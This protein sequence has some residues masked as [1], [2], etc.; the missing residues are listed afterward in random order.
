MGKIRIKL[1]WIYLIP[2]I[3]FIWSILS[4]FNIASFIPKAEYHFQEPYIIEIEK[5]IDYIITMNFV[6]DGAFVAGKK[7][8]V[9]VE[10]S[11][12]IGKK[13]VD[14][15]NIIFIEGSS[16]YPKKERAYGTYEGGMMYLMVIDG[17]E[18]LVGSEL[19]YFSSPGEYNIYSGL[20]FSNEDGQLGGKSENKIHIS[21]PE[22]WLNV[23]Q[24]NRILAL[25]LII[26]A[27][28]LFSIFHQGKKP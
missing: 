8:D 26:I 23:E 12:G 22:V 4:F 14:G 17:G 25:T 21:G 19:I 5:G 13:F 7:I 15:D 11:R 6:S 1:K 16:R 28:T 24:N 10:I 3:F 27:I 2:L 18:K 20:I 9:E